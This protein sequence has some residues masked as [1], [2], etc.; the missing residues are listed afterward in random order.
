MTAPGSSATPPEPT[1]LEVVQA[2]YAAL[3]A[4]DLDAVL[5][6][7]HPDV[8]VIQDPALPW[9]GRH[10]GTDGLATFAITLAGAIDSA[11]TPIAMFAAGNQV[12]QYGRTAGTVRASGSSFDVPVCHVWTITGGRISVLASYIDSAAMLEALER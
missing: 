5:A 11:V 12:V 2:V 9:G 8:V 3:A 10:E 4:K 6:R 7:C 1:P